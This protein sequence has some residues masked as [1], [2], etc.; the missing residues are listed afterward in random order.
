MIQVCYVIL[1]VLAAWFA[2]S[3]LLGAAWCWMMMRRE[4]NKRRRNG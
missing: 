3:L 2:F 1:G 4:V